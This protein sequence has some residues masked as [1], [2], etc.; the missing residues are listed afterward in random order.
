M[1]VIAYCVLLLVMTMVTTTLSAAA[2]RDSL[3]E[4]LGVS[5]SATDDEIKHAYR[6]LARQWH[7][8]KQGGDENKFRYVVG[9]DTLY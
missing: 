6:S 5:P 3:Y 8:D 9:D 7:P 1:R 4:V 2:S